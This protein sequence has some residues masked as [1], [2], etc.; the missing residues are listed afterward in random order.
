[1]SLRIVVLVLV[2]IGVGAAISYIVSHRES[3][4]LPTPS[5]V[6][7]I[8]GPT[9]GS[10]WLV[11]FGKPLEAAPAERHKSAV[12]SILDRIDGA[13]STW[14]PASDVSRFNAHR[15][16]NWFNVPSEIVA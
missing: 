7:V 15:E 5:T 11:K 10:H 1:M 2:L 3:Q 8:D 13:M 9:M 16:T 6:S 14:N 12:Q 4:T